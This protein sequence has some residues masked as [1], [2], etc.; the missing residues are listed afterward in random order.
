MLLNGII[1][2]YGN[3]KGNLCGEGDIN[4]QP[5]GRGGKD[6]HGGKFGSFH[7]DKWEKNFTY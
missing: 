1:Y 4:L 5:K 6:D 3:R 2:L 7:G